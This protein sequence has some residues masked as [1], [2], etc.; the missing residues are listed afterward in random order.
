[1]DL[2]RCVPWER[3]SNPCPGCFLTY[4]PSAWSWSRQ[5]EGAAA[6]SQAGRCQRRGTSL[7]ARSGALT[8][9]GSLPITQIPYPG[10]VGF[11]LRVRSASLRG[12]T[13]FL[14]GLWPLLSTSRWNFLW[15]LL[16][17]N[18]PM[19]SERIAGRLL[20]NSVT[21]YSGIESWFSQAIPEMTVYLVRLG[22]TLGGLNFFVVSLFDL[23]S[24]WLQANLF[25]IH[26]CIYIYVCVYVLDVQSCPTLCNPLHCS[27]P[28]SSVHGILQ[29][30]ILGILPF[31]YTTNIFPD[32][33]KNFSY[34]L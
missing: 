17:L 18:S 6:K 20:C 33:E 19:N 7:E 3:T 29:A 12:Y 28:G 31:P 24:T 21:K 4:P 8:A 2:F 9:Q 25:V 27:L 13:C 14:L 5:W 15:T 10:P 32:V 26:M 11:A 23:K 16:Y 34:I 22:M 1:M 30:R